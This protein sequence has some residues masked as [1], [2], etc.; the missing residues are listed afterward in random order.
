MWFIVVCTLIDNEYVYASLLFPEHFFHI[1][2]CM[3]SKFAKVFERKVWRVQVAHLHNAGR[4]LSS[5]SRCFQLSTN[6]DKDFFRYLWYCGKK[7]IECR[8]EWHWWNSTDLGL[9][10]TRMQKL[11]LVYYYQKMALQAESG[12]YTSKYGFSADLGGK[13]AAFWV[14][15]CKLSWNL[16]SPTRI[17]PL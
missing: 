7:Q 1:A 2:F 6:L 11:L 13:M 17:Q 5:L 10:D 4:A 3:L 9:I 12:K 16:F 15:A 8:L 14:C